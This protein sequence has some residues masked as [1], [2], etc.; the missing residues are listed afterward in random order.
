LENV[1]LPL[2]YSDVSD[3]TRRAKEAL[4]AVGLADRL[5]HSPGELSGGQ[6]QRVAIARA[7]VT[8]PEIIFADEPTGNLDSQSSMEIMSLFQE[9]SHK[10]RTIVL[11]THEMDI[12]EHARRIIRI[13]DGRIVSDEENK[14]PRKAK[15]EIVNETK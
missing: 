14:T 8:D 7:L 6:Q 3:I 1:E 13:A 10:G 11:V 9:L 2:I 12:A 5:H 4:T 15:E